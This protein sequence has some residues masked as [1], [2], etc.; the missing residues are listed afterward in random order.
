MTPPTVTPEELAALLDGAAR[1]DADPADVAQAKARIDA[2]FEGHRGAVEAVCLRY[3]GDPVRASELTQETLLTAWRK[4]AEWEGRGSFYAWLYGI[5]RF[6]CLRAR[7][8]KRDLL[9]EDGVVEPS[10]PQAD[11]LASLRVA[12][13]DAVLR[14]AVA[15]L[16]SLEQEAVHLRYERGLPVDRITEILELDQSSGARGL[17]QRCRRKLRRELGR[18]LV[19]VGHG[20]SLLFGS[21]DS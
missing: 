3:V 7:D 8:K 17:L 1:V 10:S 16:D 20:D 11:A 18:Q 12:E 5:A 19:E 2:L 6:Q 13:R 9:T 4:L 15:A 21:V 14:A